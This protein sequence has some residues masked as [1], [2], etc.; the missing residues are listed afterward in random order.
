MSGGSV[1]IGVGT[2]VVYDGELCEVVELR[3]C[4]AMSTR[5]GPGVT[6]RVGA[7]PHLAAVAWSD[8]L[9]PPPREAIFT[10]DSSM[11][12]S[13]VAVL[14]GEISAQES[15]ALVGEVSA[16]VVAEEVGDVVAVG[17]DDEFEGA[18]AA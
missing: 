1:R 17:C 13:R 7:T 10:S 12:R 5:S 2:K 18:A 8:E 16:H 14:V 15:S 6:V 4:V 3:A 11:W 9:H